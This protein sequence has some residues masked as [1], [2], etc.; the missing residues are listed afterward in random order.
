MQALAVAQDAAVQMIDTSVV[1]V[2]TSMRPVSPTV[3]T[4]P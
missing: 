1:R 4:K 3:A 2:S